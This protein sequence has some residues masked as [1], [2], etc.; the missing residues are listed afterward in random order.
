MYRYYTFSFIADTQPISE[1]S[2]SQK[3]CRT[4]LNKQQSLL[5]TWKLRPHWGIFHRLE[6]QVTNKCLKGKFP[7]F[8]A[9]ILLPVHFLPQTIFE[10]KSDLDVLLIETGCNQLELL[11]KIILLS[12]LFQS[13]LTL[14]KRS[15]SF[16]LKKAIQSKL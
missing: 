5:L 6:E 14:P 15:I 8:S 9:S 16:T 4:V 2:L 7:S 12:V 13:F 1:R 3:F 10:Y 11:W